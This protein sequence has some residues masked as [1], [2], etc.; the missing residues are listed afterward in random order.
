MDCISEFLAVLPQTWA[1][2]DQERELIVIGVYLF[3]FLWW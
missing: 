3:Y 1:A 2:G